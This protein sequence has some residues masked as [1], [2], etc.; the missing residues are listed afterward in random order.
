LKTESLQQKLC[1][2]E[3]DL[4]L[5]TDA[6]GVSLLGSLCNSQSEPGAQE[7]NLHYCVLRGCLWQQ[8]LMWNVVAR[9]MDVSETEALYR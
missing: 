8:N 7:R 2:Q 4:E 9:S 5:S 6:E 1:G 3:I